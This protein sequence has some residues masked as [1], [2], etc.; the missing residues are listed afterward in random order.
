MSM[1]EELVALKEKLSGL[2]ERI[3]SDDAEAIAEGVKLQ[4]EIEAKSAEIETAEKKANLLNAI[5][6]K[7][8]EDN[9]ME[10]KTAPALQT[11]FLISFVFSVDDQI[12]R[13]SCRER[14]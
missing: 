6:K 1:K 3:E 11:A 10:T 13:A 7:E 14:V 2:K 5:G 9:S 4:G 8:S 12:G